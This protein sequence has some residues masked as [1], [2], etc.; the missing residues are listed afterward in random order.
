M[1]RPSKKDLKARAERER[2]KQNRAAYV[3]RQTEKGLRIWRTWATAEEIKIYQS[4]KKQMPKLL[5]LA[6]Q[7]S[8]TPDQ[9]DSTD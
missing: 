1:G 2:K 7:D 6:Y 3:A 4:V 5:A 9:G 8:E